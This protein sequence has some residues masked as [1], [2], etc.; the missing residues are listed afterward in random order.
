MSACDSYIYGFALQER[1]LPFGTPEESADVAEA[2]RAAQPEAAALFP[3]LV[4]VVTELAAAGYD[5]DAEFGVGLDL[6]LDGV[7]RRGTAWASGTG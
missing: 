5:A 2:R 1:T 6:L 4:E 3:Y 7:E